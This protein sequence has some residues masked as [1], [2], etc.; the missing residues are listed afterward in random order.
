[1][2]SNREEG[3]EEKREYFITMLFCNIAF[4]VVYLGCKIIVRNAEGT[5][6]GR[7]D[8]AD[9]YGSGEFFSV[10]SRARGRQTCW[11]PILV[12]TGTSLP[13]IS[14]SLSPLVGGNSAREREGSLHIELVLFDRCLSVK[15]EKVRRRVFCQYANDH[16]GEVLGKIPLF[17]A[18]EAGNQS[19]C[20]ELLGQLAVEQLKHITDRGD[21]ALH[22]AARRRDVDMAR[23]LIDY[24]T[25][26]DVQN[27]EGQTALHIAAEGGDDV[28]VK[29][30]YGVRASASIVDNQD[31]TPMHLAAEKGHAQII[32]ILADK[33]KASIWERTK[34]GSTL[35]HIA[36]LNGHADCA[37][38]LFKKGVY[39]QMPNKSGARSIHTAARYGHV[40]IIS[41]LLTKGEKVDVRTNDNYTPLHIAVESCKP[42]SVET[43]LGF[44]AEVHVKGGSML[45]TP[46][47]IAARVKGGDRCALMLLK[48]GA[49]ANV[50]TD[51]GQTPVHVASRYGNLATLL[52]LLDDGGDPL[53]TS[54][55]GETPLHLACRGCRA[56]VVRHLITF[57]TS[58]KGKTVAGNYVNAVNNDGAGALHYAAQVS[59]R[60]VEHP[61]EDKE[62]IRLLLES[63]ADVTQTTKNTQETAFHYCALA[64]NNDVLV[65]MIS[66]MSQTEVQ[67][68]LNRQTDKG[69]T[70]L[71]IACHHGHMELVNTMLANHARV[72]VFDLEGRS[73]LHLA[74]EHG[75]I[76]VCDALLTHK[77][78]INSK[79]RTGFT[80]LHM[81]AMNGYTLLVRF[82]VRDHNAVI[83]VLTL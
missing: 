25:N 42:S 56:D 63:G 49:G 26:V 68:A 46:L 10:T 36:S 13:P 12:P 41:T 60:E 69:W 58:K 20:R 1:M 55:T 83:D 15:E 9:P 82:L 53:Y 70:P 16:H 72:D 37:T 76:E 66:H 21:T 59:K 79:S 44:G 28:L 48:S 2:Q 19:M 54:K 65:E 45:E 5:T 31:R 14:P 61:L 39:L 80:A 29:Y 51:D 32:E 35:M 22:L 33:F 11:G 78:F 74:A 73:A 64:G 62:V 81:A 75:Y 77:A 34:D 57:V 17:L 52:L 30:F 67:K 50:P 3:I 43:L 24:G 47:H 23:I 6:R 4:I 38:M 18:V 8:C 7:H 71:L 40:G 27:A